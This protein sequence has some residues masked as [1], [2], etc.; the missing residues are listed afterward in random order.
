[1][2]YSLCYVE[3]HQ[4]IGQDISDY[5]RHQGY[6]VD[7][8]SDGQAALDAIQSKSYDMLLLDVMLPHVNGLVLAQYAKEK[9]KDLPIIM[10]TAKG[11]IEDKA[12]AYTLG[13]DDYL[14]KPFSLKEL[15]MRIEAVGKRFAS[16]RVYRY[17]D[18]DVSLDEQTVKKSGEI[19]H[20]T[21]QERVLL[22]YL[23][24]HTGIV[25]SRLSLTELVRGEDAGR[26][27]KSENKLDVSMAAIRKKL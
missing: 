7:R 23:I 9:N 21:A 10:T 22:S 19:I 11:M 12:T 3:D 4:D 15:L 13:V 26:D 20:V 17:E 27:K 16:G 14:V 8:Y 2:S 5:L 25:V 18:L 6:T 24:E 1:M